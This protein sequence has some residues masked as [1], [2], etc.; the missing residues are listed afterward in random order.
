M[1]KP[2]PPDTRELRQFPLLSGL[3]HSQAER[4]ISLARV[5]RIGRG[6]QLFQQ[7]DPARRIWMCRSGQLKLFRLSRAGQQKIIAIV[8]P[9]RSFAEATLFMP[10]RVYPV[11]CAA[12]KPS[13]LVGYDADD[14]VKTLHSDPAA[15]FGLLGTLSRRIHDKVNQI[16]S[17]ALHN[18]QLRIAHY[19]LDQHQRQGAPASFRLEAS[20]KHIADL[21]GIQPETL[22]RCLTALQQ[23]GV[24]KMDA[25]HVSLVDSDRLLNI[26][27]GADPL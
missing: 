15:C 4:V 7:G 25:R 27:R 1:D 20:K 13:E 9:G 6:E 5:V 24:V 19:L 2:T 22:S 16:E 14:L 12:L 18:A 17:L 11:H 26:A 10:K 3:G 21:L 8:N 23:H